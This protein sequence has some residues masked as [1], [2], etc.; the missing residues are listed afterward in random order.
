MGFSKELSVGNRVLDSEHKKLHGIISEITSAIKAREVAALLEGFE[1]L[2]NCL[3]AY[4]VVEEKIA[5][6]VG[7]DF[8]QHHVAHQDLMYKFQRLKTELADK[9]LDLSKHE[10][11]N[12]IHLLC[13][14]LKMHILFDSA[15]LEVVLST[16][17]YDLRPD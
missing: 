2:E 5:Q 17:Y 3:S 16:H 12:Y 1:Q 7:F 11:E 4:F 15:P 9:I 6:A 10:E 8:K 13:R 14:H